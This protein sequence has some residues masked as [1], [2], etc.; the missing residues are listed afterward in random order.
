LRSDRAGGTLAGHDSLI[1]AASEVAV[2]I[3]VAFVDDTLKGR[4]FPTHIE[5]AVVHRAGSI[6]ISEA[7]RKENH[8]QLLAGI[9]TPQRTRMAG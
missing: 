1:N 2:R 4:A 7:A 8:E 5:V 3:A 9:G 6:A